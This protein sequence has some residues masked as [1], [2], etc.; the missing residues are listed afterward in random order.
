MTRGLITPVQ[1]GERGARGK[2]MTEPL[3]I[4]EL[5]AKA[6]EMRRRVLRMAVQADSGHVSTAMSQCEILVSLYYGGILRHDPADPKWEGRDRMLLSKGQGGIGL[7]PILADRGYFPLADLDQFTK[8]GS[9]MGVHA[10]WHLPGVE[11]LSGSLGHGL[12]IATGLALAFKQAGRDNLVFCLTGDGE[13]QEGSC[14]E[15]LMFAAHHKL[16]N[17]VVI[18]DRNG[19]NTLGRTDGDTPRDGPGLEPLAEKLTAFGFFVREVNG[20]SFSELLNNLDDLRNTDR[21]PV[22]VIAKTEKGHGLSVMC[23]KRDWHYKVPAGADLDQCWD[24]LDVPVA[25]RPQASK[26]QRKHDK[27]MR[28]RFFDVLYGYFKADKNNVIVVADN[29]A[30]S[31]DRFA[32]D[33]PGQ[34]Y[35]VGIAEQEMVGLASGLALAGKRVWCYAICPFVTTRVHEFLKLDVAAMELPVC[36]V[37][38]GA[39]TAYCIMGPTHHTTEDISIIRVLPN[40]HVYC[41]A[42]GMVAEAVAHLSA[43]LKSPHYVR[44]DRGGL[45]DIYRSFTPTL[46]DQGLAHVRVGKSSTCIIATG[47]M[48]HNALKVA[49]NFDAH[50]IDIFRLKPL[51]SDLLLK[52]LAGI[53]EIVTL[54]EHQ[55][56]GGLGSLIAEVMIDNG[57]CLPLL[58]IGLHDHFVF[59]MGGREA[60]HEKYRLDVPGIEEQVRIW[61]GQR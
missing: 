53:D 61:R 39:G 23:D 34:Y 48:V 25:E 56:A 27:G 36:M 18:V 33:F 15:A 10:E 8:R 19:Q 1:E 6:L 12:P 35:Q 3:T 49:E 5:E 26:V 45:P 24:D 31:L 57:I 21:K 43:G 41:P 7:Y 46:T 44:L 32:T 47:F 22:V 58:R 28:D 37:G 55:L 13:L 52:M 40:M 30:A 17:L 14:W 11:I 9:K 59:D 2:L 54:E 38:V 51:N 20:H 29:G 42:D 4:L 50:V 60:I 16:G